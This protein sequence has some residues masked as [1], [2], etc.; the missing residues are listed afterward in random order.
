MTQQ[1]APLAALRI[2]VI[3]ILLVAVDLN[4]ESFDLLPDPVGYLLVALALGR[5]AHL[6]RAF[7]WA[8]LAAL[9][10]VATS[11]VG[12]FLRRV[13]EDGTV[14]EHPATLTADTV[15]EIVVVVAL[16]TALIA[17][18]HNPRVTTP[19]RTLRVALPAASVVGSVLT[20]ALV[21][22]EGTTITTEPDSTLAMG[23]A[24]LVGA[25]AVVL[26]LATIVLAIWFLVLLLRASREQ[27]LTAPEPVGR[28]GQGR[29]EMILG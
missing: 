8:R 15:L 2:V 1:P 27:V 4:I 6:H 20:L 5:V 3:G 13:D 22:V 12:L 10:G 26:V 29:A 24:A 28:G 17:L 16:C 9:V 11:T 14:A 23:F 21:P 19:A 7:G 25:V 18:C